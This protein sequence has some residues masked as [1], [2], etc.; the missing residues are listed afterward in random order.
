MN[1][2]L[3]VNFIVRKYY[4]VPQITEEIKQELIQEGMIG[5][6]SA[7]EKYDLSKG[8][9]FST[10]A[11]WWIR[12]AVNNYLINVN[13]VIRVPSHI[14]AAQNKLMKFLAEEEKKIED[15]ST[16]DMSE[17]QITNKMLKSIKSALNSKNCSSFNTPVY[18]NGEDSYTL[19]DVYSDPKQ[20]EGNN[21]SLDYET[22]LNSVKSALKKMPE[23]RRTIL[24]LRYGVINKNDV[25]LKLET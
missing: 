13:P 9:K 23:K 17:L 18:A 25:T 8:T 6:I 14:R 20:N 4:S 12:Q 5:L 11:T 19:E 15:V 3:L 24:L 7:I 16:E 10:Y 22:M 21:S 2:R 1:N